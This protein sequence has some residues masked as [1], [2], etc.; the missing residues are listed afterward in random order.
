[1]T[2]SAGDALAQLRDI[3][4]PEPVAFWPPAPGWWIA[5]ALVLA[6]ALGTAVL[7]RR[8]R[9]S[10]RRAALRELET[11]RSVYSHDRDLSE[12][13]LRLSTLLR[14]VA[15]SR[16]ARRDVAGLQGDEWA[17]FLASTSTSGALTPALVGDLSVAVYA[18]RRPRDD[19]SPE[20]TWVSAVR[21]W[22]HE[23][24]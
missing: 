17:H 9:R 23:N 2:P 11:I 15:I 6:L 8:R 3:H 5:A 1:M 16:F 13:A 7:L 18:P 10:L 20:D 19:A 4:L 22:I 12:L 24:T 21:D 14:R